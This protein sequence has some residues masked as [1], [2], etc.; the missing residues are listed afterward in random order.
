VRRLIF[1]V[2]YFRSRLGF[3]YRFFSWVL[4]AAW[5]FVRQG[6]PFS[7]KGTGPGLRSLVGF[8]LAPTLIYNR[9]Y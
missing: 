2:Y 4:R 8:G 9:Q 1:P 5:S 3:S 7:L 6:F